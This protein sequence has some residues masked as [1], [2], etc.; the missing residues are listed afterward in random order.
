V[1]TIKNAPI[2]SLTYFVD[3]IVLQQEI[4]PDEQAAENAKLISKNILSPLL[5]SPLPQ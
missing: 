2:N 1:F 5:L 4:H 3:Q